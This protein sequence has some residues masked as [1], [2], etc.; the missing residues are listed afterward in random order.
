LGGA[1]RYP[2]PTCRARPK[3][4]KV[5]GA[6][7][8]ACQTGGNIVDVFIRSRCTPF[9]RWPVAACD[10][11]EHSRVH[12]K[13]PGNGL[14]ATRLLGRGQ[15]RS[16]SRTIHRSGNMAG[17]PGGERDM[18]GGAISTRPPKSSSG[19]GRRSWRKSFGDFL[20]DRPDTKQSTRQRT[21]LATP[22]G[23]IHRK[24]NLFDGWWWDVS[25]F[26]PGGGYEAKPEENAGK[27]RRTK[28]RSKTLPDATS[29]VEN[30]VCSEK[31]GGVGR[32]AWQHDR[33]WVTK[34]RRRTA[35]N[36]KEQSRF[37]L[38]ATR[39]RGTSAFP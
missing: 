34:M 18:I 10:R 37:R 39:G 5:P 15:G 23:A 35:Q 36:P 27:W 16:T 20:R 8:P 24:A 11:S 21:S 31:N 33:T 6:R 7:G 25:A 3:Q 26:L 4:K 30:R 14:T 2:A 12:S 1:R 13:C 38:P 28:P 29:P 19:N 17:E 32:A 9:C 22:V